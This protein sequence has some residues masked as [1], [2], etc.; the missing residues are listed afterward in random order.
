MTLTIFREL[1][2]SSPLARTIDFFLDNSVFDYSMADVV[3]KES[4][5][6]NT[7][8]PVWR[9]MIVRGIIVQTRTVGKSTM[10]K[11]NRAS[12]LVKK[13]WDLNVALVEQSVQ[14]QRTNRKQ[15][16]TIHA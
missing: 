13:L 11:L 1:F 6:Y 2:G 16:K 14:K 12:P 9:E 4:I 3:R 5:S 10:Y 8:R 7:L 15:K